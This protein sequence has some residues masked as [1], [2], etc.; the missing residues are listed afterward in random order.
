MLYMLFYILSLTERSIFLL[1]IC[2]IFYLAIVHPVTYM[3][4]KTLHH[5][6]WLVTTVGWFCLYALAMDVAK[7][8]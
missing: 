5:W 6:E 8:P 7:Y 4:A 2:V 1:T 3:S